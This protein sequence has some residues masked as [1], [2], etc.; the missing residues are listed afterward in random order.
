MTS[1]PSAKWTVENSTGLSVPK[2]L[3]PNLNT[4]KKIANKSN[5][6]KVIHNFSPTFACE[7]REYLNCTIRKTKW[8]CRLHEAISWSTFEFKC[9]QRHEWQYGSI[10]NDGKIIIPIVQKTVKY[11]NKSVSACGG[12]LYFNASMVPMGDHFPIELGFCITV[13]KAQGCTKHKLVASFS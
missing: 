4:L 1:C 11:H 7:R 5:W 12:P 3:K 6:E 2:K 13:P 9:K 10:T 8:I